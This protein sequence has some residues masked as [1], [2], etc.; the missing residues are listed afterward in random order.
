M[1]THKIGT[2]SKNLSSNKLI[3]NVLKWKLKSQ[4]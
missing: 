2:E 4:E 1:V 3:R